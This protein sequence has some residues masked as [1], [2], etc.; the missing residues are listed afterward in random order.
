[1]ENQNMNTEEY[2]KGNYVRWFQSR[3]PSGKI[4]LYAYGWRCKQMVLCKR[5]RQ[6]EAADGKEYVNPDAAFPHQGK[7]ER[8]FEVGLVYLRGDHP[9]EVGIQVIEHHGDDGKE[10]EAI[11]YRNEIGGSCFSCKRGFES[12]DQNLSD[13]KSLH[14]L[15]EQKE[16]QQ[17]LG[18]F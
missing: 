13:R 1:M 16:P 12:V 15:V 9:A 14:P 6:D 7:K 10:A 17:R 18:I 5:K 11:N 8:V 4:S 2:R 3:Y